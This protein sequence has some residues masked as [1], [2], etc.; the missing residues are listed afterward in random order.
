M[1]VSSSKS[2]PNWLKQRA[3]GGKSFKI[4]TSVNCVKR[5]KPECTLQTKNTI[6]SIDWNISGS[7]L[8][9]GCSENGRSKPRNGS[10]EIWNPFLQVKKHTI[11][12][13]FD[14]GLDTVKFISSSDKHIAMSSFY[15][16][17]VL[18][19]EINSTIFNCDT[20]NQYSNTLI[21]THPSEPN[22][23]WSY[24]HDWIKE[25]D[26]RQK[27]IC[28]MSEIVYNDIFK[29]I[30]KICSLA[31]NPIRSEML[32]VG[33]T[34]FVQLFD[35]RLINKNEN[36][37][38]HIKTFLPGHSRI[39]DNTGTA[40]VNG[41]KFSQDGSELLADYYCENT[42]LFN[43][44]EPSHTLRRSHKSMSVYGHKRRIRY[45]KKG[46][47]ENVTF[48]GNNDEF[49]L[50]NARVDDRERIYVFDKDTSNLIHVIP[51]DYVWIQAIEPHPSTCIL[52]VAYGSDN[53][54]VELM[55]PT[56]DYHRKDG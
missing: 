27:H 32:A 1:T 17:R 45:V 22:I 14:W 10:I 11:E 18:D 6:K 37:S 36:S 25:Y 55:S 38:S 29:P 48:F 47:F 54:K 46:Y 42:Y 28:H 23:I 20:C 2:I 19:I 31:I 7:L 39:N 15:N 44:Y 52:A 43:T 13:G 50:A 51:A 5:L 41:I 16:V 4:R 30:K 3:L 56:G 49:I 24:S 9:I 21:I 33:Q 26:I 35:R 8:A 34:T 53:K 12:T 40:M